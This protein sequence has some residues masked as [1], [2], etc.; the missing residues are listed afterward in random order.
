MGKRGEWY[1]VLQFILI[2]LVLWGPTGIR[3]SFDLFMYLA[4]LFL[5]CGTL[6]VILGFFY[7][8]KNLTPL[9]CPKEQSHLVQ[10]GPYALIRH[11]IYTGV[12]F[13]GFAWAFWTQGGLTFIYA[14]ILFFFLM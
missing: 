10:S 2:A 13:I 3:F 5:F 6:F 7:L 12:I 4:F 1:V 9:P 8:G 11:P 14:F